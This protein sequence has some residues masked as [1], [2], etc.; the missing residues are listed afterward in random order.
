MIPNGTARHA[1]S[2]AEFPARCPGDRV[3][4]PYCKG[5]T[6]CPRR[7]KSTPSGSRR[8]TRS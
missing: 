1:R 7:R 8:N 6:G 4:F 5:G 3:T 2:R